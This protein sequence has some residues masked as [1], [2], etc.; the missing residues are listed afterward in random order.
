MRYDKKD[1]RRE[2]PKF[3]MI[4]DFTTQMGKLMTPLHDGIHH[5]LLSPLF[6]AI[7]GPL[8]KCFWRRFSMHFT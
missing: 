1:L 4:D 8:N 6:Q 5:V 2:F 3:M 7:G